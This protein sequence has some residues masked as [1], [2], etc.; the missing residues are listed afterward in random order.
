MMLV[1]CYYP[2]GSRGG[3]LTLTERSVNTPTPCKK[4]RKYDD[5]LISDAQ[6]W[7][8]QGGLLKD[9]CWQ[10]RINYGSFRVAMSR[11]NRAKRQCV[12][13]VSEHGF[14]YWEDRW[15]E[16]YY[17]RLEAPTVGRN[18]MKLVG[19]RDS[20]PATLQV[21]PSGHVK[22]FPHAS[23][24]RRWLAEELVILLGTDS[25]FATSMVH[26]LRYAQKTKHLVIPLAA[27]SKI[28]R[29]L[30]GKRYVADDGSEL[31]FGDRSHPGAI[32][33]HAPVRNDS[34]EH[35]QDHIG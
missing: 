14:G 19:R 33:I 23:V 34:P 18:K 29:G 26:G 32:E 4:A 7:Q 27:S 2:E 31:L 28:P 1:F 17:E 15:P 6:R 24:W 10:R 8:H 30:R 13:S 11:G 35:P 22:V 12:Y 9:F 20:T 3:V 25:D 5:E 21:L 16:G